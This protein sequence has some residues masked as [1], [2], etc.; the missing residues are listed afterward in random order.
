MSRLIL[1]RNVSWISSNGKKIR[2][3]GMPAILGNQ[4]PRPERLAVNLSSP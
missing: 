1:R 4:L 2:L 3:V